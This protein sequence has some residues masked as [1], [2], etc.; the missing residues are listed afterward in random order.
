MIRKRRFLAAAVAC[1][2]A[3][4]LAACGGG[5]GKSREAAGNPVPGG[6]ARIIQVNEPR[7]LDPAILSNVWVLF[8]LLGNALYGNL[9]ANDPKTGEIQ[10]RMAQ[11][12]T[13]TDNG[14]TFEMK[15][16]PGLKFADGSPLDADAVKFS[17]DRMKDPALGSSTL[18][19][20]S[21]V[22]E[23]TVVDATTLKI[24][25]VAPI[26]E[27][28]QAIVTTSLN[29][30]VSPKSVQAGRQ[31][32]DTAPNG[33]GPFKLDRWT[34]QDSIELVKNPGYWDAPKPYLDRI[35]LRSNTES[36]Q[37]L[38]TVMS[39]GA[40]VVID[41][42]WATLAKAEDA[43]FPTD[44]V[45]LSG[46]QYLTL[47]TQRAPFNDIRARQALSAALDM[48]AMDLAI[49]NGKGKTVDT[50]FADSSPFYSPDL[51]LSN[52]DKANAQRLFDELA[53]EGKPVSFTFKSFSTPENKAA[54]ES[55]QAQL[56]TFRNVTAKVEV[57]DISTAA[58][59]SQSHDY[60]MLISSAH[61]IDPEPRL[62]SV[63]HSGSRANMSGISDPQLD[64]ALEAGR[65]AT[66][67]EERKA[68]YRTVQE[69]LIATVPVIF[70]TRTSPAVVTGKNVYGVKQYGW[71][72]LLPEELW[73]KK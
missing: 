8:G 70:Y 46:G 72:S 7:S 71:G 29:W 4:A 41:T 6:T 38:N 16:R 20:A 30:V 47:N 35:S 1:V 2:T 44:V 3:V 54:A 52:P 42:S 66:S 43:G 57:V 56:S 45:P 31:A 17:W 55:V 60:D 36:L 32:F 25:M 67:T 63:F 73:I 53:A 69:R 9:L 34:R 39:G 21:L 50:L 24:K 27:F 12:F 48:K 19:D 59:L 5:A 64:A 40:D 10:P 28:A 22:A 11:S 18:P 49:Y 62:Y 58:Q 26:P 61:F 65:K 13:T 14:A 51:K 23:T 15:L 37:R 68:A 33:A